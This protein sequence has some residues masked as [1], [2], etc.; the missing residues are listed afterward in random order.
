M[1]VIVRFL[2]EYFVTFTALVSGN[3]FV[4]VNSLHVLVRLSMRDNFIP[5]RLHGWL[6]PKCIAS[7]CRLT[8]D[9]FENFLSH[10]SQKYLE[11]DLSRSGMPVIRVPVRHYM[12][13]CPHLIYGSVSLRTGIWFSERPFFCRINS[14]GVIRIWI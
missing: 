2:G 6:A 9:S 12:S 7:S 11:E 8:S 1:S 14:D 3:N 10:L 4:A 13:S 5:H